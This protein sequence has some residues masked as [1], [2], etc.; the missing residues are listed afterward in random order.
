MAKSDIEIAHQLFDVEKNALELTADILDKSFSQ[1][2]DIFFK[3]KGRVV[4]SGMGKSGII[5]QKI[6]A[7]FSSTGTPA[8]FLHPAEAVHGDLGM[9][10]KGDS[11]LALSNSGE[12]RE[13]LAIIPYI[14]SIKAPLVSI[15]GNTES[16]LALQSDTAILYKIQ[17]EG[18][19]LNLAPMASTTVSLAIGDALAAALM[20]RR[21]F[22]PRDFSVY[23]PHG[24]L[25][26][27][28][29]PVKE[30]MVQENLPIVDRE[31]KMADILEIMV[32]SNQGA[33]LV[34]GSKGH[35]RGI[36]SDGDLK[37][38]L[39]ELGPRLWDYNAADIMSD[40]PKYIFGDAL[41]EEAIEFMQSKK[42]S[43]LPVVDSHK[44][45]AGLVQLHDL[46]NY[47]PH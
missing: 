1:A 23:H 10:R 20:E 5:G 4:I 15:S 17:K 14:K 9:I 28:L 40:N 44:K 6:A 39:R 42:I 12:T 41:L 26:K 29:T 3:T 38:I 21:Q 34:R 18:C 13:V 19:P 35:L 33:V 7:T 25:G 27:M 30:V 47:R 8:I 11:V 2:V 37:R 16:T 32:S 24:S 45:I 36:I 46:L 31:V 43:I 22:T